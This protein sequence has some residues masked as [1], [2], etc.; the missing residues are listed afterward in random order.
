MV[1]DVVCKFTTYIKTAPVTLRER[2]NCILL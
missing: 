2:F 1:L